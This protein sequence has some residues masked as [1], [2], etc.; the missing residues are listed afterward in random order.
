MKA[1]PENFSYEAM[2]KHDDKTETAKATAAR[3]MIYEMIEAS[4]ALAVQKGSHPLTDGCNC[5]VCVNKR[6]DLLRGPKK[7]WKYRL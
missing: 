7:E 6:K 2:M 3:K 5:I 1:A 4:M